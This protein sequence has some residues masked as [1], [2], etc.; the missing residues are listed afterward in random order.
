[1]GCRSW[2]RRRRGDPAAAPG[3]RPSST[4]WAALGPLG[5]ALP[6]A[7]WIALYLAAVP[8]AAWAIV[9][10]VKHAP[11]RVFTLWLLTVAVGWASLTGHGVVHPRY[12]LALWFLTT[13]AVGTLFV[14]R[15]AM[16]VAAL[17]TAAYLGRPRTAPDRLPT[18][19]R[20][21]RSR[22]NV[23]A[24]ERHARSTAMREPC[25]S[26]RFCALIGVPRASTGRLPRT[27]RG[28]LLRALAV[29]HAFAP[30]APRRPVQ[31]LLR[32]A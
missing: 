17:V 16:R 31:G 24:T 13:C 8:G 32:A 12:S 14:E 21:D 9:H 22:R 27:C 19:P 25:P 11:T 6:P 23:L 30:A 10:A 5:E 7:P 26:Q 3:D 1:M 18:A 4:A 2:R 28:S 20:G 29:R 15:G